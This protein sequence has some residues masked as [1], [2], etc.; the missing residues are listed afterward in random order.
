MTKRD[1][2][3]E[4]TLYSE[5]IFQGELIKL[6]RDKVILPDERTTTREVIEHPGAVVILAITNDQKI[7]SE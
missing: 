1:S 7:I 2:F 6:R 3:Q 4:K 5:Y